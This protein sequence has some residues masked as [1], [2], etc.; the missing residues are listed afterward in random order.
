MRTLE[1]RVPPP[2]VAALTATAMWAIS[3]LGPTLSIASSWRL[4]AVAALVALGITCDLLGLLAFRRSR[5]TI[6]PM[7]PGKA[8]AL[9]TAGIYKLTRNPMYLGLVLLLC[10]WAFY[11]AAIWP[12]LGPVLF[13]A[14]INRFQIG[15]EER[16]MGAKFRGDYADY[17][18]RVRRWI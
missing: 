11:L 7:K 2:I 1:L 15:P 4:A 13:I 18:S 8:S 5:T 17:V 14:Y 9:V 12:F 10:A 6:N 16:I 3:Q